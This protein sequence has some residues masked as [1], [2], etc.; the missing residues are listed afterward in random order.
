MSLKVKEWEN[1]EEFVFDGFKKIPLLGALYAVPRTV[2]YGLAGNRSQSIYS[3]K[4]FVD[5]LKETA[6][7]GA[8]VLIAP[9]FLAADVGGQV[10]N[11][12]VSSGRCIVS[13]KEC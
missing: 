6:G 11:K 13:K 4:G 5:N 12:V 7:L 1:G 9:I 10:A 8:S 3:A 2:T